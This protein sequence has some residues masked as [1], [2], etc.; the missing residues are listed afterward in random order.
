MTKKTVASPVPDD[1]STATQWWRRS[2]GRGGWFSHMPTR[3]DLPGRWGSTVLS[4]I[5][6]SLTTVSLWSSVTTRSAALMADQSRVVSADYA[7]A[8]FQVGQEES[9]ERK[10]RVEP[11]PEVRALHA[12][13]ALAL[14]NAMRQLAIDGEAQERAQSTEIIRRNAAYVRS[15]RSLFDATDLQNTVLALQIDHTLVDPVSSALQADV[16]GL[17][18]QH[19]WAA[20]RY[21]LQLR[22]TETVAL[23][24]TIG[25]FGV[26]MLLVALVLRARRRYDRQSAVHAAA[27][28]R[29]AR[30][31]TLT[32]LPN[33]L[34]FGEQLQTALIAALPSG[35]SVGVVLLDLDRFKEVN[36]TLGHHYGDKLLELVGPRLRE[37][38]RQDDLVARLGGDEFVI[39]LAGDRTGAGKPEVDHGPG[40]ERA[41]VQITERAL[42]A[43]T[44]PFIVEG[45][46]LVIEASAGLAIFPQDGT[47][48]EVLLQRADIAMYVAKTTHTRV[49]RYDGRLD[50][51]NPRKLALMAELRRAVS[52][53]E[54]VM[55]YQP[56]VDLLSGDVL[57]V[58]ALVRWRHPVEGVLAP[59][60]FIPLA[61]SSGFIH[62]LTSHVLNLSLDQARAWIDSGSPMSMSVNLSARCLLDSTLPETVRIALERTGV[63]AGLLMLE[64]TE[65]AIMSDP[66]RAGEVIRRLHGLGVLLSIDDFGTGY[67]S[68]SYLRDLPV[69]ELKIDRSFVMRML[70]DTKD[71]VIVHTSI[72]LAHRLGMRVIAEGVEDESTWHALQAL[73]CDAAQGY[74]FSRALPS[75]Q[76]LGWLTRWRIE[77]SIPQTPLTP[78][79]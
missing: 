43:L 17:A 41:Y 2:Q 9:L 79:R 19:N 33:R 26:G 32:G 76:L 57:G 59:D 69:D 38:L 8:R 63:P 55:Y 74:L 15:V 10:Y 11:L 77:H 24:A 48:T 56:T 49:T 42:E 21:G 68:M 70:R 61:E 20:A 50:E 5:L 1:A 62:E 31:D 25:V 23:A 14:D 64:I 6:L 18:Q 66:V 16:Y 65:S 52:E 78:L 34:A 46:S 45:L 7:E 36:D 12:A 67:T 47:S 40:P 71:A 3:R 75:D 4:L 22:H 35:G 51:H 13:A 27:S 30:H 44:H 37:V 53:D 60:Q 29:Q 58:E 73:D 28:E 39:M 72:D 54:L